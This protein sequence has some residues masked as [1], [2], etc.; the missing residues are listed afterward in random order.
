MRTVS[1][2]IATLLACYIVF[3]AVFFYRERHD[4][5]CTDIRIVV[6]DSLEKHFIDEKD[7]AAILRR[8]SLDP[9]G[10]P[11]GRI[12]TDRIE[13]TLL[14]NQMIK[15]VEAYKTPS[16]L[17]KLEVVQK[18]PVLRVMGTQGSYYVDNEGG[19]MPVSSRYVAHV[20]VASGFVEKKLAVT[21]LYEFALFLQENEFWNNQIDQIFVTAGREIELIP[22]VGNHR[23]L[24]GSLD[25]FRAK[26]DNLKL[27]YRQAIPYVGWEKYRLINLKYENQ[28]VCTKK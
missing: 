4:K 26:L 5:R 18:M 28:I 24:L 9:V 19:T 3:A 7:V 10:K 2:I 15:R 13:A 22:R 6:K 14:G 21:G 17:V 25:N 20:P 11:M 8:S 12:N 23:I 1:V 16:G 27:F